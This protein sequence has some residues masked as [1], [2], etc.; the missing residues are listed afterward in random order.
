[1]DSDT[2]LVIWDLT[3]LADLLPESRALHPALK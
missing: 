1:M 2:W 3:E